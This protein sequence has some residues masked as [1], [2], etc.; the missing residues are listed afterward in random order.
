MDGTTG[1]LFLSVVYTMKLEFC[2]M[3]LHLISSQYRNELL[4]LALTSSYT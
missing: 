2:L 1:K 3:L 4:Q